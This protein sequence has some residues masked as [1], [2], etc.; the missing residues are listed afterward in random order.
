M[1]HAPR[2][3]KPGPSHRR[4]QRRAL[5][6][7]A[8]VLASPVALLLGG[9]V[10]VR[11]ATRHPVPAV[12]P[13]IEQAPA[14]VV[15]APRPV[16]IVTFEQGCTAAECHGPMA[17]LPFVHETFRRGACAECHQPDTGGH[18]FPQITAAE[19]ACTS[20]H[21]T[22]AD[23]KFQ[24]KAMSEEA[25]L[26]CHNPHSSRNAALLVGDTIQATCSR[27]HPP[28]RGMIAHEPYRAG[29]CTD[30]HDQH[31][32]DNPMLL[33]GGEGGENCRRCH[34]PVVTATEIGTH[35]HLGV[36]GGC[37]GCHDAHTA[38]NEGLLL[39]PIGTL[40]LSCHEDV[41][42]EVTGARVSHESVMTGAQCLTCHD[43]HTSERASMLRDP[44]AKL[45]LSCHGEDLAG[46]D[47]RRI[48]GLAHE[49]D[50]DR[51]LHGA[52]SMGEC[53]ACHSVHGGQYEGLLRAI[54]P[55]V[56]LGDFDIRNYALCFSCH[57]QRL[58]GPADATR[59]RDGNRNL[60]AVHLKEEGRSG[61]CTDCHAVHS[62][63]G[64]RMIVETLNYQGSDWG[65]PMNFEL[66]SDGGSCAPA[67]HEKLSYSRGFDLGETRN[68]GAP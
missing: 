29:R 7:L 39:A 32:A 60:H 5:W 17:G 30:C 28:V 64:P 46:A 6:T 10:I 67:C 55:G 34:A 62:G 68:G 59:F 21:A 48:K 25:C 9:G 11:I 52:V 38:A 1:S 37:L 51:A 13:V 58:T 3:N 54:K 61:G 23:H 4:Q 36:D 49:L 66:T 50:G 43:P 15:P 2:T 24:H 56:L 47:G 26:A 8:A 41:N 63:S 19:S 31:G 20:C 22:G 18:V 14:P 57:D 12:E 40:C 53:S 45:C 27:C 44:Q 35:T 33:L 42:S 65:T 16:S